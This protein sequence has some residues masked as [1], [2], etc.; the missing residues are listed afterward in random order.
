M[1]PKGPLYVTRVS[2][3]CK[4]VVRT[5]SGVILVNDKMCKHYRR[6]KSVRKHYTDNYGISEH[7]NRNLL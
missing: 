3:T 7:Y 5:C 2:N 1:R 4:E 6:H